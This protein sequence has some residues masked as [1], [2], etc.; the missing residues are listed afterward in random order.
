[1]E[2]D[3]N[4]SQSNKRHEGVTTSDWL[5]ARRAGHPRRTRRAA[6]HRRR[7]PARLARPARHGR[8]AGGEGM[9]PFR[10]RREQPAFTGDFNDDGYA[11][12]EMLRAAGPADW[13]GT[14]IEFTEAS[15]LALPEGA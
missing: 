3:Y 5:H 9:T 11:I 10:R 7:Q 12:T 15:I 14:T 13:D 6:R 4:R 2:R 1:M 8:P